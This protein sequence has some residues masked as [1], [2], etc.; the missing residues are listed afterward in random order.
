M[1]E[2]PNA[3]PT[4]AALLLAAALAAVPSAAGG[5][6]HLVA[7]APGYPG[8]TEQAQPTMDDF[9]A[10]IAAAAD[11]PAGT[12][13]AEYHETE[14]GGVA[15]LRAGDADLAL[16]P[17][18]FFLK[19][20]QELSLGPLLQAVQESGSASEVWSL[21]APAGRVASPAALDGW[22]LIAIPA[23]A[24]AFV[25][26]P[27]LGAWGELPAS[28]TLTF[29]KRV[30]AGLRRVMAGEKVAVLLDGAQ[31]AALASLPGRD[32]IEVVATS[33]PLLAG[34]LVTVGGGL[35][36]E[37]SGRLAAGMLGVHERGSFEEILSTLR[38]TRFE[39]LDEEALAAARR[40][41]A[42]ALGEPDPGA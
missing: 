1:K 2:H 20:E 40:A 16:V 33:P 32:S 36:A 42:S 9:A 14:D 13:S 22:E 8:T 10:L 31:T 15:R 39:R 37:E 4:A 5:R 29:S 21:V 26:G 18:P 3:P 17:L 30:L 38:L 35:T 12:V 6:L 27:V 24:P 28:L 11:R 7:C 23:Y 41:Y 25:G 34:L 19:Y